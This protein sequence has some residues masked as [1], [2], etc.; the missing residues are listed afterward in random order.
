MNGHFAEYD[1]TLKKAYSDAQPQRENLQ[2]VVLSN[3]R[4]GV[5]E[6]LVGQDTG[7]HS[8]ARSVRRERDLHSTKRLQDV[9]VE[10][11]MDACIGLTD[12]HD[13]RDPGTAPLFLYPPAATYI[14]EVRK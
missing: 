7:R 8:S 6:Q 12:L 11:I 2:R 4:S 9:I 3:H 14:E 5:V 10:N 13:S 1:A